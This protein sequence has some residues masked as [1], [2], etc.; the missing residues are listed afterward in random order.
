MDFSTLREHDVIE[1]I[2]DSLAFGGT[3]KLVRAESTY[4]KPEEC[5]DSEKGKLMIVEFMNDGTPMFFT[6]DQLKPN[7]WKLK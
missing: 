6:V 2:G 7:D 5:P 4:Q 1:Y 3:Y